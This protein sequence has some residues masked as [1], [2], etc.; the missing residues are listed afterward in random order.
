MLY[1]IISS[2]EKPVVI[3]VIVPTQSKNNVKSAKNKGKCQNN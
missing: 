1:T 3:I 2:P